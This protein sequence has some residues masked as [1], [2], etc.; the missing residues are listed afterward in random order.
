M[1]HGLQRKQEFQGGRPQPALKTLLDS[2]LAS[3]PPKSSGKT[4]GALAKALVASLR[5]LQLTASSEDAFKASIGYDTELNTRRMLC[6]SIELADSTATSTM[7]MLCA[8][9]QADRHPQCCR[10]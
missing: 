6:L 10:M 9:L 1:Y 3:F 7:M 2:L 5:N 8:L 4:L